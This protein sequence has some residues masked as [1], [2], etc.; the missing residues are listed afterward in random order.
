MKK[1]ALRNYSGDIVRTYLVQDKVFVNDQSVKEP[2]P[3]HMIFI[4]DC[5]GSMYYDISN[6]REMLE[7][8]LTVEDFHNSKMLVSILSY[9]S[10]GDVRTHISR[11]PVGDIMNS[12]T[13][14]IEAIRNLHTR[15]MT[16]ISQGLNAAISLIRDDEITCVSVH[17][18]GYANDSSPY[19]EKEEIKRLLERYKSFSNVF[20]N[21]VAYRDYSDFQMLS[22]IANESS[23]QCT[24]ATTVKDVYNILHDTT[25]LLSGKMSPAISSEIG[26]FDMQVFSSL[27]ANK[28]LFSTSDMKIRGVSE[29]DD[30]T[31]YYFKQVDSNTYASS[32]FDE[33]DS[34]TYLVFARAALSSGRIN[35]SKYALVSSRR[36]DV[37]ANHYRALTGP[38]LAEY[39]D[40]LSREVVAHNDALVA[41]DYGLSGNRASVL[42]VI[43]VLSDH[44]KDFRLNASEFRKTYSRRSVKRV[45]GKR[46][47]SGILVA[48]KVET[49]P[50]GSTSL[51]QVTSFDI[52]QSNAT[53]NM[54]VMQPISIRNKETGLIVESVKGIHLDKLNDFKSYTIVGDGEICAGVLPIQI[55]TKTLFDEL[56]KIDESVLEDSSG[57][58]ASVFDPEMTYRINLRDLPLISFSKKVGIGVD[59]FSKMLDLT[60]AKKF[61]AGLFDGGSVD[62]TQDQ[63]DALRELEL[64]PSLYFS[65]PTTTEYTSLEDAIT[66]GNIDTRVSYKINVGSK[67]IL[68]LSQLHSGNAFLERMYSIKK[69]GSALAK[70]TLPFVLDGDCVVE[71]KISSSKMKVTAVDNAMKR[72][73]DVL[74][75]FSKPD[76]TL[77]DLFTENSLDLDGLV[78]S[79]SRK[80]EDAKFFIKNALDEVE[81]AIDY[82][83]NSEV[84]PLVFYIGSTGIVPDD[85]GA[86][87]YNAEEFL[88][89][90]PEMDKLK[91]DEQEASFFVIGDT[92]ITVYSK[93]EYY[94]VERAQA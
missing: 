45:Q 70:A 6:V 51:L 43:S 61:L 39:S 11:V 91:K 75:G 8:L 94:T 66:S 80:G 27:S 87:S 25:S 42:D 56:V 19:S 24:R 33:V 57:K 92:V 3:S 89:A 14:Y 77:R 62:Y 84:S 7:R 9:A 20:I 22:W 60:I 52:N 5:S 81:N 17:S 65:P 44:K 12:G 64:T 86:V 88:K 2:D 40:T 67:S 54:S 4:V 16:C 79:I 26:E 46:D 31:V 90:N 53:I 63:I 83:Y 76:A 74:L 1:F 41:S 34:R 69:E 48:P 82:I 68:S 73:Y 85:L 78:D 15:G 49:V 21:T 71:Q 38:D 47:E 58:S 28:C 72:V 50:R 59:S 37:L 32:D 93:N 36:N 23:G 55:S 10:R 18:D 35:D 29:S 30:K 13:C